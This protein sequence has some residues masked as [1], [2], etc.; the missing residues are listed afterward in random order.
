MLRAERFVGIR[1][2][3]PDGGFMFVM[4]TINNQSGFAMIPVLMTIGV[5]IVFLVALGNSDSFP[6]N[7]KAVLSEPVVSDLTTTTP[8]ATPPLSINEIDNILGNKPALAP[9]P[10]PKN[11]PSAEPSP[12]SIEQ[13]EK[14]YVITH[15]PT[16]II[17]PIINS[18]DQ[19]TS[20]LDNLRI[21][22]DDLR[23]RIRNEQYAFYDSLREIIKSNS[24]CLD[25]Q[26]AEMDAIRNEIPEQTW[27]YEMNILLSIQNDSSEDDWTRNYLMVKG[28][29]NLNNNK[30]KY[31]NDAN[32]LR[33]KRDARV[34][35][36]YSAYA[37]SCDIYSNTL[38]QYAGMPQI[39]NDSL[40]GT[41]NY[42]RTK[43]NSDPVIT[44]RDGDYTS[45]AKMSCINGSDYC[46]VNV[47]NNQG[48]TSN[49]RY[50]CLADRCYITR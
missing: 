18:R 38:S 47:S 13:I 8:S 35:S 28:I 34:R 19:T 37:G 15:S 48:S 5:F 45:T 33:E 16:P 29:A 46:Y 3:A 40:Y 4:K 6:E 32:W 36:Y 24:D 42:Y 44:Y 21:A 30:D 17:T 1:K 9:K 39:N 7:Q 27:Q 14:K 10:K 31:L 23:V 20:S 43:N 50:S 49:Y 2:G 12:I 22:V 26:K 25:K 11:Q 41:Y